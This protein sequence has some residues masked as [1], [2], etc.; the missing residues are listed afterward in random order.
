MQVQGVTGVPVFGSTRRIVLMTCKP[1]TRRIT[2]NGQEIRVKQLTCSSRRLLGPGKLP[3]TKR[4]TRAVLSR[5]HT[6]PATG[7]GVKTGRGHWQLVLQAERALRRG[8]YTL[9]LRSRHKGRSVTHRERLVL[10]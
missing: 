1:T 6:V 3:V 2:R 7:F 4:D 9:A 5:G 10:R 8:R